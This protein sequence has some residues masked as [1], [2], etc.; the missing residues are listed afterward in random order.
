MRD[1]TSFAKQ[2]NY[3]FTL[4]TGPATRTSQPLAN[5]LNQLQATIKK[6]DMAI[7]SLK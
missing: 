7:K 2:N 5:I 3:G 4:I 1:L 6:L